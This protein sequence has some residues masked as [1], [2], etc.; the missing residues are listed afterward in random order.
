MRLLTS[1]AV[2][3]V[4]PSSLRSCRAYPKYGSTAVIRPAAAHRI[5]RRQ[6]ARPGAAAIGDD[7]PIRH[8]GKWTD[9]AA[10]PDPGAAVNIGEW[11]D[12]RIRPDLRPAVDPGIVRID[13]R[14]AAFHPC[15][16]N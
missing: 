7:R 3:G 1:L 6:H 8:A 9:R 15:S 16:L 10:R 5:Q 2:I 13:D 4:R 14:H 11:L 12:H